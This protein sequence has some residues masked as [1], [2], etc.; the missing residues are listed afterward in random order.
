MTINSSSKP[1]DIKANQ[2]LISGKVQKKGKSIN[3]TSEMLA[4]VHSPYIGD[5]MKRDEFA[6]TVTRMN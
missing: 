5:M 2:D 1:Q 4:R 6:T 3:F